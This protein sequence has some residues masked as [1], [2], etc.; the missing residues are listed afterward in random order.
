[1][2]VEGADWIFGGVSNDDHDNYGFMD[3]TFN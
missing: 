2:E 1:M 3:K